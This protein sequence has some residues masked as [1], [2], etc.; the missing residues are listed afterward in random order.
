MESSA[1]NT[2]IVVGFSE[3]LDRRPLRFLKPIPKR[4]ICSCCGLVPREIAYVPCGHQ[5]CKSCYQQ[6]GLGGDLTCALDSEVSTEED[7]EWSEL[8]MD[9]LMRR[10][11]ACWNK[12]HGCDVPTTVSDISRHFHEECGFHFARCPKCSVTVL[13]N[14]MLSHLRTCASRNGVTG[15]SCRAFGAAADPYNCQ[16]VEKGLVDKVLEE[17]VSRILASLVELKQSQAE[18]HERLLTHR[19]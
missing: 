2:H 7:I 10:E 1:A 9:N 4:R 3:V 12:P 11:V 5:F 14:D 6:A 19:H 16:T 13:C 8:P 15:A 17:D 18:L